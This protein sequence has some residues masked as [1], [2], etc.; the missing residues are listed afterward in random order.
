MESINLNSSINLLRIPREMGERF[1]SISPARMDMDIRE[2]PGARTPAPAA[3][4]SLRRN[5]DAQDRKPDDD[6]DDIGDYLI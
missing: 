1:R 6:F 4:D 2:L 3:Y 5:S